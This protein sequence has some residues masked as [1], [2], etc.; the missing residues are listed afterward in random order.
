MEVFSYFS[1]SFFHL[2]SSRQFVADLHW[3]VL[4][5]HK[6]V[7]FPTARSFVGAN[8]FWTGQL[9]FSVSAALSKGRGCVKD[10]ML[11]CCVLNNVSSSG[12]KLLLITSRFFSHCSYQAVCG[13]LCNG[14]QVCMNNIFVLQFGHYSC[15]FPPHEP[16]Q[17]P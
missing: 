8:S 17:R 11:V 4:G 5:Y 16:I 14:Y 2:G 7:H 6:K 9:A 15:L 13:E 12:N 1:W 10:N 3:S